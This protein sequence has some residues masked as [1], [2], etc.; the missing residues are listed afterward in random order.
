MF[1]LRLVKALSTIDDFQIPNEE[2]IFWTAKRTECCIAFIA[3]RKFSPHLEIGVKFLLKMFAFFFAR[4]SIGKDDEMYT[5]T[6]F[7]VLVKNN[8][9]TGLQFEN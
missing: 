5:G 2:S 6:L 1:S 8:K 9:R 4:L 3:E 7:R